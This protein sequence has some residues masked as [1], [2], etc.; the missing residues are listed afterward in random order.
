M[1]APDFQ[2]LT[3][4]SSSNGCPRLAEGGGTTVRGTGVQT[5][6][7][8]FAIRNPLGGHQAMPG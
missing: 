2:T 4:T 8:S 1:V 3:P 7:K 5:M 6:V